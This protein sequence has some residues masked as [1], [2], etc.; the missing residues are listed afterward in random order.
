MFTNVT[1]GHNSCSEHLNNTLKGV[2]VCAWKDFPTNKWQGKFA[3]TPTAPHLPS[4][5]RKKKE[6]KR[7]QHQ[8]QQRAG[9]KFTWQSGLGSSKSPPLP[10]NPHNRVWRQPRYTFPGSQQYL[11]AELCTA[12]L[13]GAST[14][15]PTSS[16]LPTTTWILLTWAHGSG[17]PH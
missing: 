5:K 6:R 4:Q 17:D 15:S 12:A 7:S 3:P 14:S 16:S 2:C 9:E 8:V 1:H 10:P 11:P 13:P